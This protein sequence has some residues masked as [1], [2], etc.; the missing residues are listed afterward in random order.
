MLNV[1]NEKVVVAAFSQEKA[2]VGLIEPS[3]W[4]WTFGWNFLK[5]YYLPGSWV[6]SPWARWG[7]VDTWGLVPGTASEGSSPPAAGTRTPA[8]API[9]AQYW[10]HIVTIHQSELSIEVIFLQSEASTSMLKFGGLG[11]S[12]PSCRRVS[13]VSQLYWTSSEFPSLWHWGTG[14]TSFTASS[15]LASSVRTRPLL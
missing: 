1:L 4:L 11:S 8:P 9:R 10:G 14:E 5:H 12:A 2:L 13:F 15:Y 7:C 3:P 6:W